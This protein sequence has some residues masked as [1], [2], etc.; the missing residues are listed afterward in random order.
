MRGGSSVFRFGPFEL[1]S[2]R[3]RLFRGPARVPLSNPQAAILLQLVS[4]GGEVISKD[5]LTQ[6]AW[7]D[8]AV[9]D[10]SLDQAISRLRKALGSPPDR[11]GYIETVPNR[12][13]RFVA[14]I[15]RAQRQDPDATLDAQL[16]PFLAFSKGQADLD[17]LD[18]DA[19]VRARRAFEDVLRATPDYVPAHLGLANACALAFESTRVDIAPDT[20]ALQLAIDHARK[21]CALAPS[22]AEAWSTLAFAL[23]L[24]LA[25]SGPSSSCGP[26]LRSSVHRTS[27]DRFSE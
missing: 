23:C 11:T 25:R 4:N 9:T 18:R 6:A 13:Y 2:I 26:R 19:I 17:T 3:G 27:L 10:N 1:D 22:S 7:Q 14:T 12:G 16:V 21:G 8:A 20:A 15:E 5:A 24:C